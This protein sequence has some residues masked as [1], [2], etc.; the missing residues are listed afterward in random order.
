MNGSTSFGSCRTGVPKALDMWRI[1]LYTL[2]MKKQMGIRI[3]QEAKDLLVKLA[4][5]L[6]ISQTAVLELA[7]RRLAKQEHVR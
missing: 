7:T 4:E 1:L 3:S 2:V 5:H 6:G